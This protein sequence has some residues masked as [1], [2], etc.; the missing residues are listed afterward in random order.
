MPPKKSRA[1]AGG[2]KAVSASQP[3]PQ[4]PTRTSGRKR[5]HSDGSNVS[6]APSSQ[7]SATT[8]LKT[9]AKRRKKGKV[10]TAAEPEVIVEEDE[11]DV[12]MAD[13]EAAGP[14]CGATS[15]A[16]DA[17][18]SEAE[19][20][21]KVSQTSTKQVHFETTTTDTDKTTATNITPYPRKMTIKR[22]TMSPSAGSSTK[23]I[24]TSRTSLP[25]TLSQDTDP[26]QIIQEWQFAPLRAVLDE[27]V[28]RLMEA[29]IESSQSDVEADDD[30]DQDVP[31][32]EML[33]LENHQAI[34]YPQLPTPSPETQSLNGDHS[35][36]AR[37]STEASA[38]RAGWNEE[39]RRFG[40]AVVALQKEADLAKS[41][42]Q[43]LTIELEALGFAEA[44]DDTASTDY[45]NS[46]LVIQSIRESFDVVRDF[47]ESELPGTIPDDAENQDL[48]EI[49]IA[50]LKEFAERLRTSDKE[51]V[52]KGTLAA[53]LGHQVDGLLDH[54]AEKEV[55][56]KELEK[57]WMDLDKSN[58]SKTTAITE[59]ET[60]LDATTDERDSEAERAG[61]LEIEKAEFEKTIERLSTS[62]QTYRDE[63]LHL[64]EL[65]TQMEDEHRNTV[66]K[67]NKER[68]DTV[69]DLE[70]RLDEET[71]RYNAAQKLADE[72]DDNLTDLKIN[73]QALEAE[74]DDLLEKLKEANAERDEESQAKETAQAD[75]EER[76]VEVEDLE[77]RVDRFE[78]EL[79]NLNEELETLRNLNDAERSQREG[80]RD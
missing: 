43:V 44:D 62:L 21:I 26:G 74:R 72:R 16:Q 58:D 39:R 13:G 17:Q 63:E 35:P 70:T 1:A 42:L 75:L 47:L 25:A 37:L 3:E 29:K 34:Q 33:V 41:R 55:R 50:N 18:A 2:T 66:S 59:L 27:R 78:T 49:L 7:G 46:S 64:T 32:A 76:T 6:D 71:E 14:T 15:E 77:T 19:D 69:R 79:G 30:G 40:D 8:T 12:Q 54:L 80:G 68:E 73:I 38:V 22:R 10:T 65:I 51:L 57:Q 9:P 36:K 24:K 67:M 61:G 45:S 5:R 31:N 28:R 20:S 11:E 4:R 60:K 53:D 23:R 48:L 52:E 56:N